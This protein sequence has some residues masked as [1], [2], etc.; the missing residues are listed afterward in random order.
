[1]RARRVRVLFVTGLQEGSFP[2]APRPEPFLSDDARRE[3]AVHTGLRL[4][5][6]G[7]E[8]LGAERYLFYALASR[9]EERLVL[10]WHTATDDGDPAVRSF[11]V[12]DVCDLFDADDLRART[13]R[14]SLGAVGWPAGE[15][16]TSGEAA[17][18]AA[19][20]GPRRR[21]AVLGPLRDE[22]MLEA[23]GANRWSGTGLETLVGC[24]VRWFVERWLR[25]GSIEPDPEPM[26]RGSLAHRLLEEV[27][28]GLAAGAPRPLRPDDLPAARAA[29]RRALDE[30]AAAYP[31]SHDAQRLR[32]HLRRL[33]A[34]LDRL[35][36][37]A[38]G[39]GSAFAPAHFEVAFGREDDPL[40]ALDLGEGLRLHGTIDRVDVDGAGRALVY[41]YKGRAGVPGAGWIE[42]RAL[43][44]GLY[45]RAAEQLLGLD[46][47]GGFY[48]AYRDDELRPRGAVIEGADPGL[49]TVNGDAVDEATF[50]ALLDD[51][52][53][54]AREAVAE[55]R[56][57]VLA[58][59]PASCAF[60][61]GPPT[62]CAHPT[63][64]RTETAA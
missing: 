32:A 34:D 47:V 18:A 42:R 23:L 55:L 10:S 17:R 49:A 6:R 39:A 60:G 19:L 44:V 21:P 35:L 58:A 14:R 54:V 28:R 31:I 33:E 41:D 40:P 38:V 50:R 3:L 5:R 59:R 36:A 2:P 63:I 62:R 29:L 52:V 53:A 25:P 46:P 1:M 8:A 64:C 51:V 45:L 22:G 11:F 7:D 27:L 56:T 15:A 61:S 57:G 37:H 12:D 20:A 26:V 4:R 48:Q 43:Q 30:H 9:P 13:R 16:P 24:G